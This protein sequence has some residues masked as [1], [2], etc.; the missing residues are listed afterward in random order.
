MS[1][2]TPVKILRKTEF[3]N[4]ILRTKAQQL[5][6]NEIKSDEI[7]QLIA[8]IKHTLQEKKYGIGLAAPQVG[9]SVALSIIHIRPTKTR[10]K[11][12]KSEWADLVIINP[13]ITNKSGGVKDYWEGCISLTDVFAKV[14]RYRKITVKYLD[15]EAVGQEKEFSGLLAHVIQHETDH[16]NGELFVDKVKDPTTYMSAAEY[17]ERI[18]KKEKRSQYSLD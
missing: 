4:P 7:R 15:E 16:L 3:G 1:Q 8:D 6:V 18:V 12:P 13:V 9:K 2:Q 5:S 17:R 14:P 10:P 11:L